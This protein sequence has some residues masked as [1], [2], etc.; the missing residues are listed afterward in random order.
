[1]LATTT[2]FVGFMPPQSFVDTFMR[3]GG[4]SATM[5]QADFGDVWHGTNEEEMGQ[6]VIGGI[7]KSKICPNIRLFVTKMK[8]PKRYS[9]DG[10]DLVPVL[11]VRKKPRTQREACNK[12]RDVVEYCDFATYLMGVDI[13]TDVEADPFLTREELQ[14]SPSP[15]SCP[16]MPTA[17]PAVGRVGPENGS[18]EGSGSNPYGITIL[19]GEESSM[20]SSAN[21]LP[22][23][24]AK[25]LTPRTR[26]AFDALGKP[27]VPL[28]ELPTEELYQ[29]T[30]S[31]I[32]QEPTIHIEKRTQR[33]ER[34]RASLL[35]HVHAQF[36][37][38]HRCHLFHLILFGRYA[39]FLR[40]DRSGGLVTERFDY[41][42]QPGLLAQFF[43]FFAHMSDEQRGWDPS[44]THPSR[45]E[46]DLF[47]DAVRAWLEEMKAPVTA[48]GQYARV[49]PDADCTLD[50][51]GTFPTWKIRVVNEAT[52]DTTDL[53]VRR[54]FAGEMSLVGRA[55]RA[56]VAFDLR[57][58]RLVFF[59]DSWRADRNYLRPEFR[60]LQEL[61]A[62]DVPHILPVLYGG[63][64]KDSEGR[65]QGTANRS[66]SAADLPWRV[67][68]HSLP[69]HT[70][71]RIVQDIVYPLQT[72][73]SAR[74]LV[75]AIHDALCALQKTHDALGILHRD[76]SYHNL[77]ITSDGQG[78]LN[79]W[80]HAGPKD[81]RT[82]GI[83]TW[84]FMSIRLL[85]NPLL[86]NEIVDDLESIFWVLLYSALEHFG[87]PDQNK[88]RVV[89]ESRDLDGH[90]N[91]IG[92]I[93]KK[94]FLHPSDFKHLEFQDAIL[95]D[96]VRDAARSW[97]KYHLVRRGGAGV[98]DSQKEDVVATFRR[99]VEPSYWV[100]LFAAALAKYPQTP[101]TLELPPGHISAGVSLCPGTKRSRETESGGRSWDGHYGAQHPRKSKRLRL[102]QQRA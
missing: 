37:R 22:R 17:G 85:E 14:L 83:G 64:V 7:E 15:D 92:G 16:A 51:S 65:L 74:E 46:K 75:Q 39:R 29:P 26:A 79:D 13:R 98:P 3:V 62:H 52:G 44:V 40:F 2:H 12:K 89:F 67:G 96:L 28:V 70:H 69:R 72:A 48:D 20:P 73:R 41:V 33:A 5:P 61:E 93:S 1:M 66:A 32:E 95:K 43:W 68:R 87:L 71:H 94:G 86:T 63:D 101:Q 80:D 56:Y 30:S 99:V 59:K 6:R 10:I 82:P 60:T 19:M 31:S 36:L 90:G 24:C 77:M 47:V 11:G 102:L 34:S 38:Q 21:G 91:L 4:V 42:D 23:S 57:A 97:W 58:Q 53:I 78:V 88:L 27:E 84:K 100:D 55:T 35:S 50:E 8:K 54:P 18:S 49:L 25:S 45:K 81:R 9:N 76:I